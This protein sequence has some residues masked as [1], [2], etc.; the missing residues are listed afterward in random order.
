MRCLMLRVL[1]IFSLI[2][3]SCPVFAASPKTGMR[4]PVGN[5]PVVMPSDYHVMAG[6]NIRINVFPATELSR[7]VNVQPDGT[8]EMPLIGSVR[9]IGLTT[10]DMRQRLIKAYIP[11]ITN[12]NI[13]ISLQK[14]GFRM[15]AILGEISSPSYYEYIEGMKILDLLVLAHGY[16]SL[17]PQLGKIKVLRQQAMPNQIL[18]VDINKIFDGDVSNNIPLLAGDVVFVP[19]QKVAKSARWISDNFLPWATLFS[20]GVTIALLVRPR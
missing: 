9:V 5:K 17:Y 10:D 20:F 12:P 11:F 6:D 14:F 3:N 15:V 8:I 1:I 18:E 19:K 7:D 2:A 4:Q 13:T 16:T